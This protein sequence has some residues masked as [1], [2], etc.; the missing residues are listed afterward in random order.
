MGLAHWRYKDDSSSAPTMHLIDAAAR[1]VM[2]PRQ[3]GKDLKPFV[4]AALSSWPSRALHIE[5]I[6]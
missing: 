2:E 5:V 4:T 3:K 6:L 1:Y